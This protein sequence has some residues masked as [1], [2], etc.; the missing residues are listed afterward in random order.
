VVAGDPQ[1]LLL[2]GIGG[3]RPLEWTDEAHGITWVELCGGT[4]REAGAS[5]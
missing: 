3:C 1:R 2:G 5:P 4:F